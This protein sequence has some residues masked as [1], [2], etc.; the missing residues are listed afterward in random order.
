MMLIG[1]MGADPDRTRDYA[2]GI[3]VCVHFLAWLVWM[4][5]FSWRKKTTYLVGGYRC[6]PPYR[7][8]TNPIAFWLVMSFYSLLAILSLGV[9]CFS[10]V[11]LARGGSR[12]TQL[13]G[14]RESA[15][16]VSKP[17]FPVDAPS[18]KN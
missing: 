14:H 18:I 10:I 9:I 5:V 2:I 13:A 11:S 17:A 16:S 1:T 7:R 12:Q 4:L 3:I 15:H 6:G 8:D